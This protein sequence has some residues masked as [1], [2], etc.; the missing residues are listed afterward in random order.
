MNDDYDPR[1]EALFTQARQAF[2]GDAFTRGVLERIDRERRRTLLVWSAIGLAGIV[3]LA[4]LASPLFAALSMATQLLPMSLVDIETEWL[5]QL[6]SPINSVAAM[7]AIG[8]LGIRS[9]FRRFL[10]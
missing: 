1:L 6:A 2:D 10:G 7:I 5:R 3:V 8:A 4:L 9:F